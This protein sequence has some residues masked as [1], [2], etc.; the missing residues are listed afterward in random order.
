MAFVFRHGLVNK[1]AEIAEGMTD[2]QIR[3]SD[4]V[5]NTIKL[6]DDHCAPYKKSPWRRSDTP[7]FTISSGLRPRILPSSSPNHSQTTVNV[8]SMCVV[9]GSLVPLHRETHD[10]QSRGFWHHTTH[11]CSGNVLH[12]GTLK[13]GPHG[14]DVT[15]H[16]VNILTEPG[17]SSAST[18][19]R[20]IDREVEDPIGDR[21]FPL[22]NSVV[23][24]GGPQQCEERQRR[25]RIE[26]T[27][28]Y[29]PSWNIRTKSAVDYRLVPQDRGFYF[30]QR[31]FFRGGTRQDDVRGWGA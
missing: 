1:A 21:T 15:E 2:D 16:V 7:H 8:R 9:P 24:G 22:P 5:R 12:H 20:Q 18:A 11:I 30:S 3:G 10:G 4:G 14:S 27:A 28:S 17:Y 6:F 31:Q 23:P 29:L 25:L 26:K 13:L 19:E